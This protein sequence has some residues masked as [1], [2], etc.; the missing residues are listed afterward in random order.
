[1]RLVGIR[2][3]GRTAKQVEPMFVDAA[4]VARRN[5]NAVAI[6]E[7]E[8][9]DGDLAAVVEPVAK[10]RGAE[11]RIRRG[12]AEIDD[13]VGP[14]RRPLRAGKK[15]SCAISSALPMRPRSLS[16]RRTSVSGSVNIAPISR[17]A[18]RAKALAAADQRKDL[19]P[20]IFVVRGE[21]HFV[22][23][24]PHPGAIQCDLFLPH[25]PMKHRK[26]RRCQQPR[27]ELEAA[28]VRGRFPA[29]RDSRHGS[30]P[31]SPEGCA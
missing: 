9:L 21:P 6:E 22:A 2:R 31:A 26:K 12:R 23:G 1:M 11:L 5:V 17:T 30:F 25:E 29:N 8:N 27:L 18:R 10:L 16:K 3:L 20:D 19:A 13:D 15:W 4:Q 14:F 7:F 28:A 24:E